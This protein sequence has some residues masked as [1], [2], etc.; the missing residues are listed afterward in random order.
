MT[1]EEFIVKKNADFQKAKANETHLR[2]RRIDRTGTTA[3]V[4]EAWT[5]MVQSEFPRKVFVFERIR[6]AEDYPKNRPE[7]RFGYYIMGENGNKKDK[8]TWGQFCPLIPAS[9]FT[10]LINQAKSHGVIQ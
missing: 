8:W 7:Y 2:F 3:F 9:D 5:F 6:L 1:A 4:R 10:E